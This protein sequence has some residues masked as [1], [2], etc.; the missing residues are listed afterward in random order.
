MKRRLLNLLT[1]VSLVAAAA[2]IALWVRDRDLFVF[3]TGRRLWWV[4][5]NGGAVHTRVTAPWPKALSPRWVTD[6]SSERVPVVEFPGPVSTFRFGRFELERAVV[7]TR[8][9]AD[10]TPM[11]GAEYERH[12]WKRSPAPQSPPLGDFGVRAP[13]WVL[14]ALAAALPAGRVVASLARA[15]SRRSRARR[16]LC[17]L[18]GYDL[19]GGT[20]TCPECG[21]VAPAGNG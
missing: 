1:L 20:G 6:N 7:Y 4:A 5:C 17:P 19:R 14:L 11:S 18:C 3:T 13:N 8:F 9:D 10:G 2:V 15:R 12:D 21:P 16:G